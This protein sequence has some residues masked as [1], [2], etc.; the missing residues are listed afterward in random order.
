MG[1][2]QINARTW[3]CDEVGLPICKGERVND[4][5][6]PSFPQVIGWL[7]SQG[8]EILT[9]HSSLA[10]NLQAIQAQREDFESLYLSALVS[11]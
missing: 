9:K 11:I 1:Q 2:A 8:E 5:T 10:D 7:C 4:V 3:A 6:A